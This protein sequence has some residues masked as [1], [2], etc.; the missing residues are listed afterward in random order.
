MNL[1]N[2]KKILN[3]ILD[4]FQRGEKEAAIAALM[5]VDALKKGDRE[6]RYQIE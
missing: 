2:N 1:E 6:K 4:G 5:Y 3:R